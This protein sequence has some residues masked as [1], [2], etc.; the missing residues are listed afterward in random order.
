MRVAIDARL[1]FSFQ[2]GITQYT[3]NLIRALAAVDHENSYTIFQRRS[4][5]RQIASQDNFRRTYLW[6]PAHHPLEQYLLSMELLAQ[7]NIDIIHWTDFIPPLYNRRPSVITVHDLAFLLYPHFLTRDSAKY[8]GLIDQ[9]VRRA[10]HIIAVSEATKR[11]LVRLTG[12]PPKKITVIYEAAESIYFPVQ[13]RDALDDICNKHCLPEQYILFVGTVEPRKNLKTLVRA[14]DMLRSNY[15]A[16]AHL[17]IAG[18]PGWLYEDVD[19]LVEELG[20]QNKIHFLGRVPTADLPLLYNAAQMLVLPSFYEGFGLP[21]LEAMACGI[22]VIVSNTSAMPEVVGDAALRVEPGDVEGF[23]VAMNRLLSET[24]L[25]A[26]MVDKGRKRAKRF[27][28]D[29]AAQ[30]TL[31]VYQKLVKVR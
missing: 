3:L 5:Q 4:D 10:D 12:T 26:D 11:D 18:K 31:E 7:R 21:P 24:D 29:R 9:A 1:S 22:P 25:R 28:W 6:T 8:Y 30:E 2:G 23:A 16:E 19:Q 14:F 13:D 20:L 27:S 15:K 17:V